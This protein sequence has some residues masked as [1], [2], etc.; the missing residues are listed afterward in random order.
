MLGIF[1]ILL[2]YFMIASNITHGEF[3][4]LSSFFFFLPFHFFVVL[5][6]KMSQEPIRARHLLITRVINKQTKRFSRNQDLE[7]GG[8]SLQLLAKPKVPVLV[9]SPQ[10]P[11][12]NDLGELGRV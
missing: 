5:P 6:R 4:P 1:D 10:V 11:G 7:A 3:L 9:K 8:N 2:D 12:S